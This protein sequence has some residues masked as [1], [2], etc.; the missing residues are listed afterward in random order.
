M[1][2]LAWHK[3][4]RSPC[5]LSVGKAMGAH[6]PQPHRLGRW[7]HRVGAGLWEIILLLGEVF[8]FFEEASFLPEPKGFATNAASEAC[9]RAS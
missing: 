2:S 9:L 7:L 8:D 1:V 6:E 3:H 5:G 4:T